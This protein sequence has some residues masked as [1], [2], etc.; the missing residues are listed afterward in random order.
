MKLKWQMICHSD[1]IMFMSI[2]FKAQ[3]EK[4]PVLKLSL[5]NWVKFTVI[6]WPSFVVL[7]IVNM[8]HLYHVFY[9]IY[10][11]MVNTKQMCKN[12]EYDHLISNILAYN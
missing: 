3:R 5:K 10:V 12:I 6:E 11:S 9:V 4:I 1:V 2:A 7:F 8:L